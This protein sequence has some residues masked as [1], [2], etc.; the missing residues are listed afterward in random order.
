MEQIK[1]RNKT[2]F[3]LLLILALF[4]L[5]RISCPALSNIP[6]FSM[7]FTFVYGAA[8]VVLY[9][10]SVNKMPWQDFYLMIAAF[11]YTA[12]IFFR[13][14]VAGNSLFAREAF[15][16][17][18]IV[19]LT[20][21]YLWVKQKPLATK[22]LLFR[23]ILAALIFNYVYSIVVLFFDPGASRAA[24]A[25]GVLE[26]SPYDVLH[27][28]GS[29]DAVYG[30]LSVILILLSMRRMMKEKD[31][32]NKTTLFVLILALVFIIMAAY[33]TAL[34]LLVVALALFLA[35]KNRLFFVGFVMV[36]LVIVVLHEPIGAGI[37]NLSDRIS[38]SET[39]SEKMNEVG[40][41]LEH[42]EAA[43]TYAGENGRA[44]RMAWSWET[45]LNY[46][47]FGGVGIYGAK[48]GGHSEFLDMLGNFGL[49]GFLFVTAY[50]V[51]L[52]RNIRTELSSKE[53]KTCWKIVMLVF[54]ISSILNPSLYS[55]QMMPMIL[56]ISLA[57][58]YLET[59]ANKQT[60]G[61]LE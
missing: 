16:A 27:A 5:A 31:I 6:I 1:E 41:M 38:F 2:K 22:V 45:F 33:G 42:F 26:P 59:C 23:F 8:F 44:A 58:A 7:A 34:V 54:V 11:F 35:Q 32:K 48:V 40:Y 12:Y 50:L 55:L 14:L 19:F 18:I 25:L 30:G 47:I 51:C 10:F 52:Y 61:E 13:G 20:M 4:I 36:A 21:I 39:I 28:V 57:P 29:F 53:M 15:N 37:M 17:Y 9:F 60:S 46:P 49:M 24:A 3:D 56:M 43:G